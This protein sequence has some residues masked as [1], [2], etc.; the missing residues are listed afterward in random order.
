MA[1]NE[2]R[3]PAATAIAAEALPH[4]VPA[5]SG[6]TIVTA[7]VVSAKAAAH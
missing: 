7:N 6:S 1:L 3:S 5:A 4:T 2:T